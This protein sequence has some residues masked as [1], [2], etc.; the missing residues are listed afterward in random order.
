MGAVN[1]TYTFTAT[2]TITSAKMNNIIDQT[3]MTS[4]AII[5]NTL[6][7]TTSGQLAVNAQ[8]ITS[9]EMASGSVIQSALAPNV[10]SNGPVFRASPASSQSIP[11]AVDT[12]IILASEISDSNSNFANNRFTPTVAGYYLI[13]GS[14]GYAADRLAIA[15][16]IFKNGSSYS[17]GVRINADTYYTSVIDILYLNG[18]TD[19]VELYTRQVSGV[20]SGTDSSSSVTNFSGCLIR[21]A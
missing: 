17:T 20:D 14:V 19:Y 1:T 12:K 11:N 7:V 2:D 15:A 8:G 18:S 3:T 6:Q 5:G 16:Y 9:N 13:K 10:V 21:S 4:D